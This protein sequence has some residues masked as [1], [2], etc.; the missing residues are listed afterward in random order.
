[1]SADYYSM[2]QEIFCHCERPFTV[3]LKSLYDARDPTCVVMLQMCA[4]CMHYR[5]IKTIQNYPLVA[6][7]KR[8]YTIREAD[9]ANTM[10]DILAKRVFVKQ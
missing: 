8:I 10:S 5:K 1:M 9:T 2:P 4:L 3:G 6:S 7:P